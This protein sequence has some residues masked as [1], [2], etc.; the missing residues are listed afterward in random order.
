MRH[1]SVRTQIKLMFIP[2]VNILNFFIWCNNYKYLN[3]P[4][5]MGFQS[6]LIILASMTITVVP[7]WFLTTMSPECAWVGNILRV[8]V[9][10]V[11]MSLGIIWFQ[12]KNNLDF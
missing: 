5:K 3:L 6:A 12:K 8:Y 7:A 10:P 9:C 2:Y 4:F 1:I 11:L